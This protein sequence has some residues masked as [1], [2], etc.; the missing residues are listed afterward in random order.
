MREK[1]NYQQIISYRA[2]TQPHDIAYVFLDKR[3]EEADRVTYE[4]LDQRIQVLA[5]QLQVNSK[6][7]DRV[8]IILENNIDYIVAFFA[9]IYTNTVAVTMYAPRNQ[10][11]LERMIGISSDCGAVCAITSSSVVQK[12]K[13]DV[14]SLEELQHL[15]F[16]A[17][18]ETD[19]TSIP[20]WKKPQIN[21]ND[22][23]LLQYTSGSTSSPKGVM[24]TH[25]N[26]MTQGE[27]LRIGFNLSKEDISVSWLPLFHDMGLII[28]VLQSCYLGFT[29]YLMEPISF[30]RKPAI[31]LQ[32]VSKYGGTWSAAPNFAFDLCVE[33]Y[34]ASDYQS[35]DLS[36][37]KGIV[38][39]A[40]PVRKSTIENFSKCFAHCGFRLE[41]FNPSYGMAEATL[42]I[43][44]GEVEKAPI[45][46]YLDLNKFQKNQLE[47]VTEDSEVKKTEVVA[48][49]KV[50][51]DTEVVIVNLDGELCNEDEIGELWVRGKITASGYWDNAQATK[52]IFSAYLENGEGP[53]L[54]TGDLGFVY[55]GRIYI[56]GR[57]KDVIIIHGKNHAPQDIEF[58]VESVSGVKNNFVAAFSLE[59]DDEE[60]LIV[61]SQLTEENASTDLI[62]RV[63]FN[64]VARSREVNIFEIVFLPKGILPKTTSGKI[65]RNACKEIYRKQ[66]SSFNIVRN[67][68]YTKTQKV[69]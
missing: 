54:R 2:S 12:C 17:V 58:T 53:Y 38:N 13:W 59:I 51:L 49:G 62:A 65:Q 25:D 7:Q 23:A 42:D 24:V 20:A 33:T 64:R 56:T 35:V 60:R 67:P 6:V 36:N 34:C 57:S 43:S 40:E 5:A 47:F 69:S 3:G 21:G 37:W 46:K 28:G 63:I 14:S 48:C 4:Q 10:A 30:I 1:Y 26:L 9:C 8:L 50:H 68:L 52:E 19:S 66:K 31:W 22:L 15:H 39:A 29:T 61:F 44:C 27:Y 18:D 55:E 32:T 41:Y 45:F 11:Q 16:I